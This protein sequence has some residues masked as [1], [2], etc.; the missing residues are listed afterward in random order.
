MLHRG[1]VKTRLHVILYLSWGL[2]VCKL[3]LGVKEKPGFMHNAARQSSRAVAFGKQ[4]R[5]EQIIGF[6]IFVG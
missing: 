1:R 5:Y 4:R 3:R 6:K 2:S